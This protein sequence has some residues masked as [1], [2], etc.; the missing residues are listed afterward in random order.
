MSGLPAGSLLPL[1]GD[2]YQVRVPLPFA[3]NRVNCYLLEGE[4]GWTVVDTG[5]NTAE[6]RA[7]WQ[8]AFNQLHLAPTDISQIVLTHVHPDHFGLAGWLQQ[9]CRETGQAAIPPVYMS[10]RE[11][12]LAQRFW[13]PTV[14][15]QPRLL[16]YWQACGV[17]TP[18]AEEMAISTGQTRQRTLPQPEEIHLIYPGQTV[19]IGQRM[20][21]AI[22]MPGHSDGQLVFYDASD[23]LLLCGDHILSNIT[24]NI[25]RWP[26]SDPDPLGSYLASFEQLAELD[27]R[28]VLPGH[29]ELITDLPGRLDELRGH[30]AMRLQLTK[31]AI[32]TGGTVYEVAHKLFPFDGLSVH[33][34][35][36]A[37]AESLAHLEYLCQRD[38]AR[39][40]QEEPWSFS[41]V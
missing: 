3:L 4:D 32:T 25:G 41:A 37:I 18:L 40:R 34:K 16:R 26:D 36:F 9:W 12:E 22:H 13:K 33:E 15:W 19:R 20:F 11:A 14:A 2:L 38:L 30:H 29:R 39:C 8:D 21:E 35:R 7:T 27:V 28:L 23:R 31:Q 6:A 5:L 10:P 1:N 24:S 17:P